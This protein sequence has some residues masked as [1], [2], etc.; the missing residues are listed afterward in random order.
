MVGG[1]REVAARLVEE[2]SDACA[3]GQSASEEAFHMVFG[4]CFVSARNFEFDIERML[5]D[6]LI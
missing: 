4:D 1:C 3:W 6:C 5:N 2:A